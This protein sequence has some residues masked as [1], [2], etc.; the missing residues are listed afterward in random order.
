M[1]TGQKIRGVFLLAGSVFGAIS[2][3]SDLKEARRDN[4][5]LALVNAVANIAV[6]IT[7]AALAARNLRKDPEL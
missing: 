1:S 2:A 3:I 4:D 6:V 5:K 7:G